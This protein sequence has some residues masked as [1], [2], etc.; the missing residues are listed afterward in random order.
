MVHDQVAYH[1]GVE[2]FVRD[3]KVPTT[4]DEVEGKFSHLVGQHGP[5]KTVF[6]R[7]NN[8]GGFPVWQGAVPS[9]GVLVEVEHTVHDA[10]RLEVEIAHVHVFSGIHGNQ[11]AVTTAHDDALGGHV[12]SETR[13]HTHREEPSNVGDRGKFE[14]ASDE[15][16]GE[17]RSG[18]SRL[19]LV[20]FWRHFKPCIVFFHG[21][22]WV[23]AHG[24]VDVGRLSIGHITNDIALF[25]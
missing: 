2:A 20:C 5:L 11:I 14:C 9:S 21:N 4:V 10:C 7:C 8:F 22:S 12:V 24:T 19:E 25:R 16:N 23:V 6:V 1:R 17:C 18:L 3:G 13:W 15:V